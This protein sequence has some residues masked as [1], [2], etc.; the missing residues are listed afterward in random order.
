MK[1]KDVF[2]LVDIKYYPN[3]K[4]HVTLDSYPMVKVLLSVSPFF[5]FSYLY[6]FLFVFQVAKVGTS[7]AGYGKMMFKK[8][9]FNDFATLMA[10]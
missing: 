1:G 5:V 10:M 4:H 6:F 3:T 2:P 8:K 9:H 7:H